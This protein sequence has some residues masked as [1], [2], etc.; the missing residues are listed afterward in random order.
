[1][2]TLSV[3]RLLISDEQ[4]SFLSELKLTTETETEAKR[5]HTT[6]H[7]QCSLGPQSLFVNPL[8][9]KWEFVGIA[10]NVW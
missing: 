1:M 10:S 6:D 7:K 5:K 3:K 4:S 8:I 2:S 9:L